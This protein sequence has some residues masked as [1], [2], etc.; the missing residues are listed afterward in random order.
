MNNTYKKLLSLI[1]VSAIF[2]FGA[3]INPVHATLAHIMKNDEVVRVINVTQNGGTRNWVETT[4]AKPGEVVEFLVKVRSDGDEAAKAIIVR[5]NLPTTEGNQLKGS[6]TIEATHYGAEQ[7]IDTATINVDGGSVQSLRYVPGHA[8]FFGVSSA[9]NC[10]N[11][12]SMPDSIM[13]LGVLIGDLP[14]G[15]EVQLTFKA[16]VTN[17]V[18][19]PAPTQTP[20]PIPTNAPTNAPTNQPTSTPVVVSQTK[21]DVKALPETGLPLAGVALAG[22][23]PLGARLRKY[24]HAV[25]ERFSANDLWTDRELKK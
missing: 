3:L 20:T 1:L 15:K 4:N 5:G 17:W 7:I 10:P 9:Y 8:R 21:T 2:G 25:S 12:C 19:T 24:G 18:A 11:G 23:F 16:H 6:A 14:A 13:N 22:L